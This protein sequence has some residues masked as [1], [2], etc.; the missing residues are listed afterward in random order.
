MKEIW[1]DIR[2]RGNA[3]AFMV[4]LKREHNVPLLLESENSS[5]ANNKLI[6][7]KEEQLSEKGK[8]DYEEVLGKWKYWIRNTL[9]PRVAKTK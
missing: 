3:K 9:L 8:V 7:F 4:E 5:A 6:L 1:A 2:M